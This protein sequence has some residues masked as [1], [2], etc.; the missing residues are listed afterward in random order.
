MTR[1]ERKA[2]R[3]QREQLLTL[4]NGWDPAQVLAA[5][6]PRN[7]YESLADK[8]LGVLSRHASAGEVAQFLEKEISGQFGTKPDDAMRFAIKAVSWFEMT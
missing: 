3:G 1:T 4:L 2:E 5:G 7:A 6:V 8:L